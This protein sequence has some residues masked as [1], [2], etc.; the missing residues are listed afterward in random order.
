MR[1]DDDLQAYLRRLQVEAEPPSAAALVRLHHAQL[2]RI[3]YE[4]AWIHLD[5]RWTVDLEES[6]HRIATRG[7][8]GYC[9]HVNGAFS[10]LLRSLGYD[11]TLHAGGVHG[12]EGPTPDAIENHLVL[13][14]HGL[15]TDGHPQGTWYVDAGLGDAIHGPLPLS[16]GAHRDGPFEFHLA[17]TDLDFADWSLRHHHLGSF[18]GMVFERVPTTIDRFAARNVKLSTSPESVFV[19]TL[20]VQRRDAAGVDV[21]RGQVLTRVAEAATAVRTLD[22][23]TEWFDALADVFGLT[24]D[25]VDAAARARLWQRVHTTHQAWL[26]SQQ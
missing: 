7:R 26:A 4:T 11:V 5:E 20:T 19:K 21:V 23:Q 12:P 22:T 2:E 6:V 9:F 1:L 25:D 24:L 13:L 8:G 17:R 3:P 16:P 18:T 15:P 10:V 14:V